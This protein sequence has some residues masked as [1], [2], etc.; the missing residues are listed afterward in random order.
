MKISTATYYTKTLLE[1]FRLLYNFGSFV[2]G[3]ASE[4]SPRVGGMWTLA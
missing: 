1:M 4:I 3:F 2:E